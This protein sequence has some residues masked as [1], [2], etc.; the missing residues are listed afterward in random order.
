LDFLPKADPPSAE[1]CFRISFIVCEARIEVRFWKPKARFFWDFSASITERQASK[2]A[3][4]PKPS[5]LLFL[6]V[7]SGDL[8]T[9][10]TR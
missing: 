8:T 7:R 4:T 10:E 2:S 1:K 3:S 6:A 5:L 9:Q